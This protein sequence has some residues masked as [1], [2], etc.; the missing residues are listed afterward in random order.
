MFFSLFLICQYDF[1][2]EQMSHGAHQQMIQ[3]PDCSLAITSEVAVVAVWFP[4]DIRAGP[5]TVYYYAHSVLAISAA[6]VGTWVKPPRGH[7]RDICAEL[8]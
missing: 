5:S 3:H 2:T 8:S 6:A 4:T 7:A 1:G